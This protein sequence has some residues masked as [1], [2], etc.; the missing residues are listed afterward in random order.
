MAGNALR[1]KGCLDTGK[2]RRSI[3]DLFSS[4]QL[5]EPGFDHTLGLN[6]PGLASTT[7]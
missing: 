7:I 6:G 5:Q 4:H 2:L 3:R 1:D